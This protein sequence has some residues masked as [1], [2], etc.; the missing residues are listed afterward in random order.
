MPAI[1]STLQTILPA[2]LSAGTRALERLSR[3][4]APHNDE[5]LKQA[6]KDFE[7]V[8][9]DRLLN[10]MKNTIPDSGLT[11]DGVSKQVQEIFWSHLARDIA[12]KGGLGLW[13]DL[14]RQWSQAAEAAGAGPAA[15]EETP[16]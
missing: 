13:K 14:Y 5:A 11:D 4:G 2:D 15:P 9:L 10:E 12:D 16:A 7:S 3:K 1:E 6:A 8:L